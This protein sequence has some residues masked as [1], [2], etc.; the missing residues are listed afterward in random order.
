M[1]R[2]FPDGSR[3]LVGNYVSFS[4]QNFAVQERGSLRDAIAR[5]NAQF[6]LSDGNVRQAIDDA[7]L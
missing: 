4:V 1:Q 6:Q 7:T 2:T 5:Q 3:K